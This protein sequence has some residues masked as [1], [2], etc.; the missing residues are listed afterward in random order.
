[1]AA[2]GRRIKRRGSERSEADELASVQ[3]ASPRAQVQPQGSDANEQLS[4]LLESQ[5]RA[6]EVSSYLSTMIIHFAVA[7]DPGA[8]DAR[9]RAW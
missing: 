2:K 9:M 3:E 4:Q 6:Y 7:A 8:S 1:M 5:K